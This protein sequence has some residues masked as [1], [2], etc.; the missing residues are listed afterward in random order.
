MFIGIISC[1]SLAEKRE[2][3]RKIKAKVKKST[4]F[5]DGITCYLNCIGNQLT[6]IKIKDQDTVWKDFQL[7]KLKIDKIYQKIRKNKFSFSIQF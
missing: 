6:F 3:F 2:H 1:F 5:R 7:S 4:S